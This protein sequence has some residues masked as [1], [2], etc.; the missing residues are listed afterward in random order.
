MVDLEKFFKSMSDLIGYEEVHDDTYSIDKICSNIRTELNDIFEDFNCSE[1]I[2]TANRDKKFFG[3]FVRPLY[4]SPIDFAK[5]IMAGYGQ[6]AVNDDG[7]QAYYEDFKAVRYSI[8]IDGKLIRHFDLTPVELASIILAEIASLNSYEVNKKLRAIIDTYIAATDNTICIE[9]LENTSA[10]FQLAA[11]ITIHNLTSVFSKFNYDI[12]DDVPSI[13][14]GWNL[15]GDF[16]D[17]Y[18]KMI[19]AGGVE[20]EIDKTSLMISWYFSRYKQM[21]DSRDFQYM[22]RTSIESEPSKLVNIMTMIA[23]NSISE[24]NNN[25]KRYYTSRIY[26]E[27]TKKKGLIY[28]MKRDGL[29]SIE[30]DLF[31]YNMRLRNVETQDEAIL[32]MRQI[33]SRLSILEEYLEDNTDIDEK[34]K[35]RWEECY[36]KYIEIREA[37]SKKSVYNRKMYGLF[38]DYNA[39]QNMTQSNNMYNGFY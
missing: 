36:K 23:L 39:L 5:G 32:L 38:V 35:K 12:V 29:K 7:Y 4:K 21:I 14:S 18:N 13:I 2:Y 6:Y 24:V 15:L 10:V 31:E 33:N 16:R 9:T 37:L 20:E 34:D 17:A 30:E 1:V 22:M 8:E 27:A 11:T 19:N 26:T 28:R 3:V 25:D